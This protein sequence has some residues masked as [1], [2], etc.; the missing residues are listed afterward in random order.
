MRYLTIL[1]AFIVVLSSCRTTKTKRAPKRVVTVA[2]NLKSQQNPQVGF[3]N[4][5]YYRLKLLDQ[6]E[7]FQRVNLTLAEPND[8]AD[9]TLNINIDNF[10]LWPQDQRV[11]RRTVSRVVQ[12]GTNSLGK[13]V[14][15][16]V[17]ASLDLIQVQRRSNARFNVELK[18]RDNPEK[19]FKRSFSTSYNYSNTYVENIQGDSRAVD[20]RLYFSNN[21]GME[22]Q[23]IDFLLNLSKE[24][25]QRVSSELRKQYP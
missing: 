5:E 20:P 10:M 24:M 21:T 12:T 14:Y 2:F 17:R 4:L 19:S 23:P 6:V 9:V 3:I 15:Q 7:N 8:T 18:F 1:L 16:T 25:T 13:P 11:N 22:P